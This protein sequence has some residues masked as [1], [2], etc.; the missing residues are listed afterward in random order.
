VAFFWRALL[1]AQRSSGGVE[2]VSR[3]A[4]V[5]HS[6]MMELERELTMYRLAGLPGSLQA[7]VQSNA[8]RKRLPFRC[9]HRGTQESDLLLGS[10]ADSCALAV[11]SLLLAWWLIA[12][13]AGGKWFATSHAFGG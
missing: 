7:E 8:R 10:F 12:L 5:C 1:T 4:R 13:A 2:A 6:G 9:W 3:D 11:G